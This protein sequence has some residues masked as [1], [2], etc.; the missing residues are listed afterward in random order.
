MR[1]CAH[2]K[3]GMSAGLA[4]PCV[5]LSR[6]LRRYWLPRCR[7]SQFRPAG[8]G[9]SEDCLS[10]CASAA[11]LL[12]G[13]SATARRARERRCRCSPRR[14]DAKPGGV[15]SPSRRRKERQASSAR[16]PSLSID[17]EGR[18]RASA[19]SGR[20][21]RLRRSADLSSGLLRSFLCPFPAIYPMRGP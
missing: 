2:R 20:P 18:Q 21:P 11:A 15:V 10:D 8:D 17:V 19:D 13:G 6:T 7:V 9:L 4:R 14:S 16:C 5:R 12:R 3:G 1:V